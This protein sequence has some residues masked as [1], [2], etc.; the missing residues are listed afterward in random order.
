MDELETLRQKKLDQLQ[1]QQ[2]EQFNQELQLA[3]QIGALEN[4]VKPKL[5]KDALQRY[6]NVKSAHPEK[7]VQ[8][9]VILAQIV[10]SGKLPKITD[11][12]LKSILLKIT[13][14]Q[15]EFKITRK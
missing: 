7:A 6:S 2:Q 13:P 1:L 11:E 9:L 14:K 8:L 3:Q 15:K 5:T 4:L 10:Q 12:Q